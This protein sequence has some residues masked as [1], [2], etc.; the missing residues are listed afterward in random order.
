MS[1][2]PKLIYRF[3]A[4]SLKIAARFLVDT[5]KLILKFMWQGEDLRTVKTTSIKKNPVRKI[6]LRN[7]KTYYGA[8]TIT[9]V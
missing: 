7:I 2:L 6:T 9:T 3:N 4:L 5:N 8:T 1:V